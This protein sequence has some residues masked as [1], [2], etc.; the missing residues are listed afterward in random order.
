[1][2]KVPHLAF[3]IP[4]HLHHKDQRDQRPMAYSGRMLSPAGNLSEWMWRDSSLFKLRRT[5]SEAK[6]LMSKHMVEIENM[7]PASLPSTVSTSNLH[8]AQKYA[9]IGSDAALKLLSTTLDTLHYLLLH[10]FF[11]P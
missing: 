6:Q 8:G 2:Y 5:L 4:L 10:L 3:P 7:D 11:I 9:Q 1:M